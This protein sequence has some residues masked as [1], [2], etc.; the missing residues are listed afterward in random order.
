MAL[1][2]NGTSLTI[3]NINIFDYIYPVG[4]VLKFTD[5][6][7]NPNQ[8]YSGTWERITD[9]FLVGA[10]AL[11][12]GTGG[13]NLVSL[14]EANVKKHSH[15]GTL[16]LTISGGSYSVSNEQI[17][18][19][20]TG[21]H[22]HDPGTMSISGTTPG[23]RTY[24]TGSISAPWSW[25][26]PISGNTNASGRNYAIAAIKVAATSSLISGSTS[27]NGEHSH[28]VTPSTNVS[29][30]TTVNLDE[31]TTTSAGSG[32]PFSVVPPYIGVYIWTRVS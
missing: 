19:N 23:F 26:S 6:N 31:L 18:A 5:S 2:L 14:T 11:F 15:S 30:K 8:H 21:Q 16:G 10:G 22:Y 9:K 24:S 1:I 29:I 28:T 3:N 4:T 32:T 20:V 17:T 12:S 25:Y 7:F 13:N 27:S